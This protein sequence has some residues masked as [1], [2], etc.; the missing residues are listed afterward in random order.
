V[1]VGMVG[2]LFMFGILGVMLGPLILAYLLIILEVYRNK[3]VPGLI[4][5]GPPK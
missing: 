5:E 2:G 1:L 3:K 4:T